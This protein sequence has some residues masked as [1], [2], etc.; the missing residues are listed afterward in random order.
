M[1]SL[2]PSK[3]ML[4]ELEDV[5]GELLFLQ[6]EELVMIDIEIVEVF[7][8]KAGAWHE[9]GGWVMSGSRESKGSLGHH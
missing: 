5:L 2:G 6:P 8:H 3:C 1:L 9:Q 7:L 4:V